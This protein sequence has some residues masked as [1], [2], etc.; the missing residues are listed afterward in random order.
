MF[1]PLFAALAVQ[2]K[3][4]PF[5]FVHWKYC[6]THAY[7]CRTLQERFKLPLRCVTVSRGSPGTNA[8]DTSQPDAT[9]AFQRP[10]GSRMI[11]RSFVLRNQKVCK[12]WR[13]KASPSLSGSIRCPYFSGHMHI[14]T[15]ACYRYDSNSILTR[16]HAGKHQ[17]KNS[18]LSRMTPSQAHAALRGCHHHHWHV[19]HST[20]LR[21][22]FFPR[23]L[24][25]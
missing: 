19:V 22:Q 2:P 15:I 5:K 23:S 17:N 25:M 18:V 10:N 20:A 7:T 3:S 16:T 1:L 14:R 9:N 13:H 8:C 21:P 4:F 24:V 6:I 12:R 11:V